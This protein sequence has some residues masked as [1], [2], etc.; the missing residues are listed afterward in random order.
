MYRTLTPAE[1]HGPRLGYVERTENEGAIPRELPRAQRMQGTEAL[2]L[3]AS[4]LSLWPYQIRAPPTPPPPYSEPSIP[5]PRLLRDSDSNITSH[6]E[7]RRPQ[8]QPPDGT[9]HHWRL[10]FS[11]LS[12]TEL[13]GQLREEDRV[14]AIDVRHGGEAAVCG[15]VNRCLD[16]VLDASEEETRQLR[17]KI[18]EKEARVNSLEWQVEELMVEMAILRSLPE[19]AGNDVNRLREENQRLPESSRVPE[20]ST[21][22]HRTPRG[23]GSDYEVLIVRRDGRRSFVIS[24]RRTTLGEIWM[25]T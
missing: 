9:R 19:M 24:R 8:A 15:R 12:E 4:A 14:R 25:Y 13:D 21:G 2:Q 6:G 16:E 18:R 7:S 23:S 20:Q 1:A 22:D 3:G 11:I 5:S 10:G 17:G